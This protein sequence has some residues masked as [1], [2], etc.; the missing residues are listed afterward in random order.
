VDVPIKFLE[1][2]AR[3]RAAGVYGVGISEKTVPDVEGGKRLLLEQVRIAK[4]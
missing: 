3:Q 2:V 4:L 1:D